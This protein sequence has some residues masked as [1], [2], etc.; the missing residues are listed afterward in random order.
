MECQWCG[1]PAADELADHPACCDSHRTS[2]ARARR[3]LRR[4]LLAGE[5]DP[6]PSRQRVI[7]AGVYARVMGDLA[8]ALGSIATRLEGVGS[9]G[10]GL[11]LGSAVACALTAAPSAHAWAARQVRWHLAR[12]GMDQVR[13]MLAEELGE[14]LDA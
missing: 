12:P 14:V 10:E 13:R 7:R 9:V 8:L 2:A 11:G 1:E 4:Y 5:I 3:A 6:D